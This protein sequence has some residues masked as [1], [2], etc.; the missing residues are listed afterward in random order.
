MGNAGG[1]GP[2]LWA[3]NNMSLGPLVLVIAA[4][5]LVVL[6]WYFGPGP[7]GRGS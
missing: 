5:L 1:I 7:G 3:M 2:G 6:F 4:A